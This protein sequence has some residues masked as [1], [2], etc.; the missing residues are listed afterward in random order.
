MGSRRA[1][2]RPTPVRE[3]PGSVVGRPAL[4]DC[5]WW[6]V[7]ALFLLVAVIALVTV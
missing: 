1:R 7:P 4:I 3:R 6:V 5:Y 2:L